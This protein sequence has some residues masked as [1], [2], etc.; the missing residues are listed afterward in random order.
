MAM[1]LDCVIPVRNNVRYTAGILHDILAC[2]VKPRKLYVIDNGSTD[3]TQAVCEDF[4]KKLTCMEYTR[5]EMNIGVN[6]AWNYAFEHS[7][8]DHIAVL[9]NDMILNHGFFARIHETVERYPDVGITQAFHVSHPGLVHKKAPPF[10]VSVVQN[11]M[12]GYAF[13]V[14]RQLLN[15]SGLIP[16][17]LVIYCGD[18]ILFDIAKE[19]KLPILL[20]EH[21]L[22]YHYI[23]QTCNLFRT[24]PKFFPKEVREFQRL[25]RERCKRKGVPLPWNAMKWR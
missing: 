15:I 23:S 2:D 25:T 14:S 21:N 6:P 5:H 3:N 10:K 16:E 20:M 18:Q 8:A 4:A 12:V 1:Q 11:K 17:S 7:D 24:L 22:I 13:T 19:E 9:N